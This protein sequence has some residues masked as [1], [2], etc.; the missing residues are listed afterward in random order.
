MNQAEKT[1]RFRALHQGPKA[2]V[3]ASRNAFADH[4]RAVGGH[5]GRQRDVTAQHRREP[6]AKFLPRRL[7]RGGIAADDHLANMRPIALR[8]GRR[9]IAKPELRT[10]FRAYHAA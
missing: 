7:E 10:V 3:I 2:F 8:L 1:A 9:G 4:D 6:K 5:L